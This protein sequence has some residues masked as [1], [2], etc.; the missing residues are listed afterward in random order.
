VPERIAEEVD[1]AALPWSAEHLGDRLLEAFV[2][3][4]DH[5]LH[6]GKAAADQAA[7]ELPPERFGLGR[8][9]VQ[10]DCTRQ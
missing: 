10:A 6:T 3:V 5:Q 2:G 7:Q 1:G 8:A 9:H 4:G